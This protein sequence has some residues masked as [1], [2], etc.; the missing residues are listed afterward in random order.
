MIEDVSQVP[1]LENGHWIRFERHS[2]FVI[3]QR[4]TYT[5]LD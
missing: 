4:V 1:F 5:N 3:Q 2:N